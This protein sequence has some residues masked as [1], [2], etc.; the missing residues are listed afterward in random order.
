MTQF[1]VLKCDNCDTW[2]YKRTEHKTVRCPKCSKKLEGKP[3]EL[4]DS[5]RDAIDY[6]KQEKMKNSTPSGG[7]FETFG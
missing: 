3:I 1:K 6:I 4:F 5:A 7:L 2:T